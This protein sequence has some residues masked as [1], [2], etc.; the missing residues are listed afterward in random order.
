MLS[1]D[2]EGK[3]SDVNKVNNKNIYSLRG[4]EYL[5]EQIVN[6]DNDYE[7]FHLEHKVN[8][9]RAYLYGMKV[10]LDQYRE[11]EGFNLGL[12]K[13]LTDQINI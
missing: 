4:D 7:S 11:I 12:E 13:I 6:F 2:L 10:V 8:D 3:Y 5:A 1:N 9:R